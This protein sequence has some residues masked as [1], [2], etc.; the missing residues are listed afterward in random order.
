MLEDPPLEPEDLYSADSIQVL[1]FVT[2]VCKRPQG[3][4][5]NGTLNEVGALFWGFY[6]GISWHSRDKTVVAD[7]NYF[8]FD[9]CDWAVGHLLIHGKTWVHSFEALKQLS[10]DESVGF[11]K[12]IEL[13]NLYLA[14]HPRDSH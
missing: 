13:Y 14:T 2:G 10:P 6:S 1:H 12:L 5:I 7:A 3:Y 9:F 4:T 8:W 11:A